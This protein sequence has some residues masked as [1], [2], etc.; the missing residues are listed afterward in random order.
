MSLHMKTICS[1]N[2]RCKP[3]QDNI[4]S[5][6][7]SWRK[8]INNNFNSSEEDELNILCIQGVYGYR[9]GFIGKLAN[10]A[11]YYL[12][13]YS[14]PIY[15]QSI[16]K[17][18]TD[19]DA[20]DY[21]LISYFISIISRVIP[22]NNLCVF[23]TK[24]YFNTLGYSTHNLSHSKFND[25][26][27]LFL[28]KPMFDCGSTIYSNKQSA[29]SGFEKW[30]YNK[31]KDV[32]KGILWA[33]FISKDGNNGTT[34]INIDIE[35]NNNYLSDI[36][37]LL[38]IVNLKKKLENDYGNIDTYVTYIMGNFGIPFMLSFVLSDINDKMRILTDANIKIINKNN[39]NTYTNEF[40]MYSKLSGGNTYEYEYNCDMTE[41]NNVT[42]FHRLDSKYNKIDKPSP[43]NIKSEDCVISNDIEPSSDIRIEIDS[44]VNETINPLII[45]EYVL[46]RKDLEEISLE[47]TIKIYNMI[48]RES[49]FDTKSISDTNSINSMD[50][51]ENVC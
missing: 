20:N 26:R 18:F 27:S 47:D 51:W 46:D 24:D 32:N 16:V 7:Q 17:L 35:D 34:I 30:T 9:S 44:K 38:Q 15:L 29:F 25:L 31:E 40:I 14:N 33:H 41:D 11:A 50:D 12:S 19:T 49:H 10:K 8:Y 1:W 42:Y 48:V 45:N 22:I 23:D 2:L 4:F 39:T 43:E 13:Q 37:D 21:E 3:G 36:R 5:K 28:F 6:I